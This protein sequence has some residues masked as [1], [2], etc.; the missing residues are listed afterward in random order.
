MRNLCLAGGVALNCVA[1]GK[2]LRDGHFINTFIQP[3]AGDAGGAVGA[4]LAAFHMQARQPRR[5]NDNLDGMAGGYL[6]PAF[7]DAESAS[8][9]QAA[10]ARFHALG[11]TTIIERA[12]SDIA[13]GKA[14]GWFQG[15]MEFGPRALGNRSIIADPRSP[16]MQSVLNL[17]VKFRESFRPFA[18]AVLYQ[19]VADWFELD[20]E[21]PYMLLVANV[22]ERRRRKLSSDEQG[23]FGIDKLNRPRSEIPAVTHIDYSARIQTVH[24]ATNPRFYALLTAFKARTGCPVLVNTSF[25]VRGEPIVCTP[26]DAFACFMGTELDAL[27]IGNL[28]LV[29]SEQNKA[30]QRD[31]KNAFAP[32]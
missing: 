3:A 24:Q 28:Y 32:D 5:V 23:L 27:A 7:A 30:L 15:R 2:V 25:N 17:K 20:I 9:L 16:T 4:A 29:K 11:E 1:N 19:D 10:G 6:G 31:Y 14:L 13:D 12:V 22:V 8:R 18:P 26:E 21:S